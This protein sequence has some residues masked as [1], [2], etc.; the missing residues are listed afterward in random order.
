[1]QRWISQDTKDS[2]ASQFDLSY[3]RDIIKKYK[4]DNNFTEEKNF[5]V[6]LGVDAFSVKP[7]LI[8]DKDG[9]RRGT[10]DE[11]KLDPEL[12]ESFKKKHSFL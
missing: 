12:I 4:D 3:I 6:I 7:N 11:E 9:F 10:I 2:K 1:M 5:K 8:I